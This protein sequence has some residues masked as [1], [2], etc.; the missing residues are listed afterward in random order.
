MKSIVGWMFYDFA[1]SAFTTVIVSVVFN[2]YFKQVVV[3][4]AEGYAEQLW[5]WAIGISMTLAAITGPILGAV[6]D[7]SRSKKKLLFFFCYLTLI[8]TGLL[9]FVTQGQILLGMLLFITA[10]YAFNSAN[11]FYDAFLPELSDAAHIGKVS[12]FGWAF[13]YVGGLVSLLLALYLVNLKAVRW[14]F[15][16]IAAH[17]LVFSL[18]TFLLLKEVRKPSRRTNYLKVA[19]QRIRFSLEHIAQLPNLLRYV[20]SYFI[21]NHGIYTIIVFAT[22]FGMER[23]GMSAEDMI[24]FFILAQFTSVLGAAL[25]GYLSDHFLNVKLSLSLSLLI[26]IAVVG[27]AFFCGSAG[28]YYLVGLLAGMAIGSSQANSRTLMS[29]LTPVDKQA[30]FFG[31]YTLTGRLSSIAGPILYGSIYRF[32]GDLRLAILSLI[33]FFL[34]GWIVLQGVS[35]SRGIN[36]ARS[37]AKGV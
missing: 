26:W 18:I 31:F 21:Y 9:Y 23:F 16:M 33:A 34:A 36:Q 25:F 29:L 7:Y 4:G 28:E 15:P 5:G 8:F 37:L 13:G 27:W 24:K 1:N 14:V 3:G 2:F 32:T 10:N 12:G 22:P 20:I 19:L 6:A 35:L 11:I 17:L 30:E